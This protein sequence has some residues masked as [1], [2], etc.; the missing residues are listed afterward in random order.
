M[1]PIC[2][3]SWLTQVL[4][5][6]HLHLEYIRSRSDNFSRSDRR[7]RSRIPIHQRELDVFVLCSPLMICPSFPNPCSSVMFFVH[8][9]RLYSFSLLEVILISYFSFCVN[10]LFFCM[11]SY[12]HWSSV[13]VFHNCSNYA[14]D[15]KIFCHCR[16]LTWNFFPCFYSSRTC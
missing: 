16:T 7:S 1:T 5:R 2:R 6:Q 3:R 13:R 12:T 4:D 11:G 14:Q 10:L 8:N 9:V 15:S